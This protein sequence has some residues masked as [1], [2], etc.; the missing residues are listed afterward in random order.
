[1]RQ[2]WEVADFVRKMRRQMRFGELS[3]APL[4]LLRMELRNATLWNATGWRVLLTPG[5]AACG[6]RSG[7]ITSR[8]RHWRMRL[9]CATWF[10]TRFP[11]LIAPCCG[12]FV[13]PRASL[14]R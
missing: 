11:K 14:P 10:L 7:T 13:N 12:L 9:P 6:V 5:I 8:C 4:K 1:M 3:R 2:L